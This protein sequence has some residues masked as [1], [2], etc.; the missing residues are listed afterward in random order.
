LIGRAMKWA[1][2][3][4]AAAREGMPPPEGLAPPARRLHT[5]V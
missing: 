3:L 4:A 5:H 2:L 1:E